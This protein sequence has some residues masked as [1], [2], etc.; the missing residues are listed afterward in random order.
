VLTPIETS[1]KLQLDEGYGGS[2]GERALRKKPA[3]TAAQPSQFFL[4]ARQLA[5]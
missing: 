3:W 2:F 4:E 1:S 5:L